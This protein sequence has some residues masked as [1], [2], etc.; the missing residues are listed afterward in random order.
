MGGDILLDLDLCWDGVSCGV[1]IL[2]R[3]YILLRPCL[4]VRERERQFT[5]QYQVLTLFRLIGDISPAAAVLC[6]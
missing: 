6:V 3:P 1:E 4:F 2:K 5:S